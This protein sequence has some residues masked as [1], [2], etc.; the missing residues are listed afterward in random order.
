MFSIKIKSLLLLSTSL[1]VFTAC[2]KPDKL[3]VKDGGFYESGIYFGS[4][5]SE[6]YKRGIKD[7]CATAKGDYKKSH[8]LFKTNIDY[9]DGWFLARNRCKHLLIIEDENE[10]KSIDD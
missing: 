9:N 7:G 6:G 5:F 8:Y 4:N 1:I 2:G 3:S 10:T